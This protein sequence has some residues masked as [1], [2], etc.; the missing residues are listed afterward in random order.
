MNGAG[1]WDNEKMWEYGKRGMLRDIK[2]WCTVDGA[3]G[4]LGPKQFSEGLIAGQ[5]DAVEN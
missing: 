3:L 5:G 1:A 2:D 4:R